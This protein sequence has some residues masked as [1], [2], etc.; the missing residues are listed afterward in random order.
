MHDVVIV[1]FCIFAK[2][3]ET[4][5]LSYIKTQRVKQLEHSHERI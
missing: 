3:L 4:Y 2:K 1:V 5:L